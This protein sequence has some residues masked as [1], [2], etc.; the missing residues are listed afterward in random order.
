MIAVDTSALIAIAL[1][2]EGYEACM[3]ARQEES[4]VL[5]SAETLTELVIVSMRQ[6]SVRLAV[7]NLIEGFSFTVEAVTQRLGGAHCPCLQTVGPGLP[8]SRAEFWR[9]LCI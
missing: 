6:E 4:E 7:A 1:Q 3:T 8:R 5:I 9:L 2:E